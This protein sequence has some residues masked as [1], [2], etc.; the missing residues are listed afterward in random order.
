MSSFDCSGAAGAGAGLRRIPTG[1]RLLL[2]KPVFEDDFDSWELTVSSLGL[3]LGL[4]GLENGL[5]AGDWA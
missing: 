1:W 4:G 2:P 5:R 3:G